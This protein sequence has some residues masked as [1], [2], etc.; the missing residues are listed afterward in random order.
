MAEFN[1]SFSELSSLIGEPARATMLWNL[2]DGRAYTAGELALCAN[3]SAQSASNHLLKLMKADLVRVEQHGRHRYYTI[4]KPEVAYAI[5]S[6]ANLISLDGKASLQKNNSSAGIE[7]A[8]T[9]YD[10][11]AGRVGV[12]VTESMVK[13]NILISLNNE[14]KLTTEGE[15]FF[16]K[17]GI[18][19]EKLKHCN[20]VFARQCLDW[21]ERK[22]HLAGALGAAFLSKMLEADWVRKKKNSRELLVTHTGRS[23]LYSLLKVNIQ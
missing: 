8:R 22:K 6:I 23:R 2:L 13:N 16:D 15:S 14:Y 21:S 18:D 17:L 9:C 20:R 19:L 4:G 5:E 11:L 3:I 10:H 7:Y 1:K 12:L